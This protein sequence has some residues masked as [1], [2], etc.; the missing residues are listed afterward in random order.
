M[1]LPAPTSPGSRDASAQRGGITILVSLM[2][3]VLLT[4]AAIGMSRNSFREI[5]TSGTSRQGA[6][7]HNLADSGIEFGIMWLQPSGTIPAGSGTSA[8]KLQ[9]LAT[10][11]VTNSKYGISYKLADSS[12]AA[13][14]DSSTPLAD[15]QVPAGSGNGYNLAL[16][17][18]GKVPMTDTSQ[19]TG[20]STSGYTPAA[21]SI[22][23]AAP[24][25]WSLRSDGVVNAKGLMKFTH[26]KE[27]WI[28][29]PPR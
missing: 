6:M 28:S 2:L 21:G 8:L 20:S 27:A 12:V 16:T 24:D 26:S 5:V 23:L 29:S 22:D 4:S 13:G 3:L 17:C 1:S 18:M 11:L 15:L 25:I 9:A 14:L 19:T 10:S 7:T